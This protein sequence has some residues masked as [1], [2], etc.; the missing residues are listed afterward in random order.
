MFQARK[1]KH[2][3][4]STFQQQQTITTLR[5][6]DDEFDLYGKSVAIGIKKLSPFLQLRA[7]KQI[8]DILYELQ[9]EEM[10]GLALHFGQFQNTDQT[11]FACADSETFGLAITRSVLKREV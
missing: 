3:D 8:S 5:D 11:D 6:K 7:K 10:A 9:M 4:T 2:N 1:R